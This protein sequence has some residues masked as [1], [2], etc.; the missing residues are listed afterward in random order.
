MT[1]TTIRTPR[2]SVIRSASQRRFV[3]ITEVVNAATGKVS[4]DGH[5]EKRSDNI[6][7]LRTHINRQPIRSIA[8]GVRVVRSIFDNRT[9][10]E[11]R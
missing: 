7:T 6:D 9:G 5:V 8:P 4:E 10:E 1:A 3:V 2:G 11:V